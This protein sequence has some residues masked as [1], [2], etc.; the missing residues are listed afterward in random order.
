MSGAPPPIATWLLRLP[1][2]GVG[3]YLGTDVARALYPGVPVVVVLGNAPD[4]RRPGWHVATC[5]GAG[6]HS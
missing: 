3:A 5:V 2:A 6:F 1:P 4:R